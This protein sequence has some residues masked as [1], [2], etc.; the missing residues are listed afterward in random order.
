MPKKESLNP[1][2]IARKQLD[3]VAKVIDL[4]PN[5]HERL[6]YPQRELT[7]AVPVRMD[8]GSTKAFIGYRVQHSLIRGPGKGGIRFHPGVTLDEVRALAMWMTWKCAVVNLPYG[9][10]KGGVICNPKKLSPREIEEISRRYA[11]EISIIIGANKDIPAPDVYT[12]PQIMAWMMDTIS[13]H[14]GFSMTG[15]FTGKPIEVGGS[16]GRNEATGR[17]TMYT[18]REALKHLGIP[19]KGATV[20]VQGYGNAGYFAAKLLAEIGAKIIAVS[21]SKGGISNAKGL[22]PDKVKAYKDENK[23]VVGYPG[24]CSI[25]NQ[26]LLELKCDVLIPAAL[27][28]VITEKNA[29]KVKAKIVAEAA[30]GPTTPGADKIIQKKGIF[31]IPDILANAGGVTVS[32]FEWVQDLQAHFWTLDDVRSKL[33]G[34]MVESF[35]EVLKA[36][37]EYD[38]GMR[39]AAYSVGV[40]RVAEAMKIR[41]LYY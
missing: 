19:V 2:V 3:N 28:N 13:M 37:K 18:T 1:W 6:R 10:A 39:L 17:G 35:N 23:S 22:D 27:E 15:S 33:E 34:V 25:T 12:N 14:E 41:G 9:G 31:M 32:Y 30:N 7:V 38:V 16:K 24:S 4:D 20:A 8:N 36:A 29:G 11:A 21:D 5:L 40:S 26:E